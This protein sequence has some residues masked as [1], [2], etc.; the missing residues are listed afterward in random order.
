MNNENELIVVKQL[1]VIEEYL[2]NLSLEIDKKVEESL[3]LECTEDSVKE[4]KKKRTELSKQFKD[5]ETKRKEVKN[6]VLK[7]YN[8]FEEIYKRC[9]TDKFNFADTE[10]KKKIDIVETS[11]KIEKEEEVRRY[12]EELKVEAQIEFITYEQAGIK[13]GLSDSMKSLK[14]NAKSFI[15]KVSKEIGTINLQ[16]YKEEVLVEYMKHLDVNKAIQ[17]V[18]D[19]HYILDCVKAS[20]EK[21]EEKEVTDEQVIAKIDSLTAPKIEELIEEY[22]LLFKVTANKEKLQEL[23]KFLDNGGY[24][25]E[26]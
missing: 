12:F 5:L 18:V 17:D 19:R 26:Q 6:V 4:V 21:K 7:P 20:N 24:K 11:L 2:E 23:I 13:V 14:E 8:D 15:E 16:E 1:P 3:S 25:Y 9:V 22:T 10:L